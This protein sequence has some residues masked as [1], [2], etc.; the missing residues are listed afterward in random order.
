MLSKWA[1]LVS[2][3]MTAPM[4]SDNIWEKFI[5]KITEKEQKSIH[6]LKRYEKL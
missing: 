4:V 6:R 3:M 2:F 5:F 1:S